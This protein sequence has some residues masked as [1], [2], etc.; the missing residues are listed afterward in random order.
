MTHTILVIDD[1]DLIRK[2]VTLF[3]ERAGYEVISAPDGARG[4]EEFEARHPSLIVLD[5]AMPTM[6]GFDVARQVRTV[7]ARDGLG[8]TPIILLTAYAR[9]FFAAATNETDI[10]S[11]LNK[12]VTPEKLLAHVHRFL[13]DGP[14][15]AE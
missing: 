8:R 14:D 4:L 3:L 10:D 7:E 5:I 6:S 2:M 11:Y 9:S 15:A 12:P 13:D 1:D